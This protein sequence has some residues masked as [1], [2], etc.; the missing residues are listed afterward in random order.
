MMDTAARHTERLYAAP[1]QLVQTN[2]GAI[3]RRGLVRLHVRG[4]N[5]TSLLGDIL[6]AASRPNG[7]TGAEMCEPFDAEL[8]PAIC[9]LIDTLVARRLL[10]TLEKGGAEFLTRETAEEREDVFFWTFGAD[11]TKV[12]RE[13]ST[14][15]ISVIGVNSVSQALVSSLRQ[16][17]FGEV[18]TVDHPLLRSMRF[19]G[20]DGTVDRTLWSQQAP[21]AYETWADA[22]ML[23]DCLVATSDFGGLSLMREWNTFCVTSGVDFY[24]VVLQDMIGFAGP[25]VLPGLTA[26]FECFWLRQNSNFERGAV[27]RET[28]AVAF[29]GQIVDGLFPSMAVVL[30]QVAAFELLRFYAKSPPG[31]RISTV[32]EIDVLGST[33]TPRKVLRAPR[34]P[35]C[36]A[37]R[38]H[39]RIAIERTMPASQDA[40]VT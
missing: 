14:R 36:G 18:M 21:V 15:R 25:L 10:L 37:G 35:V 3:V 7:A 22:G 20:S 23:P 5:A 40:H 29:Q 39:A 34:C 11:R 6:Q 17:G 16:S 32:I 19:C 31:T 30:G 38:K 12:E 27:H 1:M 13:L 2:D 28:E 9:D 4:E 33:M 24:S 26:C 8:H